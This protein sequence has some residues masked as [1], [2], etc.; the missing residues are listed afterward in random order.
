MVQRVH[1][2]AFQDEVVLSEE[3]NINAS[4]HHYTCQRVVALSGSVQHRHLWPS[5]RKR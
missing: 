3:S 5:V 1:V 4:I 2:D